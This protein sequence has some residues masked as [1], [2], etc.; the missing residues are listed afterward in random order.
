MKKTFYF[1]AAV[2]AL[3]TAATLQAQPK[4]TDVNVLTVQFKLQSQG[5]FSDNGTVRTYA[6]PDQVKMNSKDLLAVLAQDKYAQSN[7]PAT[8]FPNGARLAVADGTTAVVVNGNGQLIVDVSDIVHFDASTN[9]VLS[10]KVNNTTGLADAKTTEL[11]IARMTFDDTFII[12]GNNLSFVIQG[13]DKVK[14][15]DTKPG[16]G[17]NYNET[18][19]DEISN[20]AGEGQSG[21]KPFVI[22]GSISGNRSAKLSL[23]E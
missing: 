2:L 20:A 7:Y 5:G 22:T 9:S 23:P 4:L 11:A 1:F 21:G 19:T 14:T 12:G 6:N 10:G 18:S 17:G 16:S 3:S 15:T 8:F 13:V